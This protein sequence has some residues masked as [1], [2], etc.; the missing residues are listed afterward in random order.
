[1]SARRL[2][3]Y[4]AVAAAAVVVFRQ[5]KK[6]IVARRF[7]KFESPLLNSDEPLEFE[8]NSVLFRC[9]PALPGRRILQFVSLSNSEDFGA[10]AEAVLEFIDSCIV[11]EQREQFRE[12]TMSETQVVP[13]ETLTDISTF[14]VENYAGGNDE[15]PSEPSE[16][17]LPGPTTM[18]YPSEAVPSQT[19]SISVTPDSTPVTS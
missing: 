8:L 13:L 5:R 2:L 12:L 4:A 9:V 19:E 15:S 16:V 18:P 10:S 6:K 14:L 7:K 1:M 11:S 17:S 3:C